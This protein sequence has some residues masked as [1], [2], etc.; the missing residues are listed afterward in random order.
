MAFSY[1]KLRKMKGT[2]NSGTR[3]LVWATKKRKWADR[4]KEK[5]ISK[6]K[7]FIIEGMHAAGKTRE[8]EKINRQARSVWPNKT[9][10]YLRA[11]DSLA[12]WFAKMLTKEDEAAL[13]AANPDEAEELA[14][15]IKRQHV[16]VAT[17]VNKAAGAVLLVDDLDKLAG[18]K[19]EI[20]KDLIRVS[21]VVGGTVSDYR[22]LDNTIER[23]LKHKGVEVLK[24]SSEAS[25]DATYILFAF[26][27]LA[28]F[29]TQQYELAMLV[30]AGRYAMKGVQK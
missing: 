18:K 13:L 25:Y 9:I 30:M 15:N 10:I 8:I 24:M 4:S 26:F 20:V 5:Y 7:S 17:L 29:A 19:K 16:R 21:A 27:V 6:K 1:M 2:R 11:T 23:Q 12:D 28:L 3:Y 22:E 14:A